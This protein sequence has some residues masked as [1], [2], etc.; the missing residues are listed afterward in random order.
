M[1]ETAPVGIDS[2]I[3]IAEREA[4]LKFSKEDLTF[5]NNNPPEQVVFATGSI[6]KAIMLI[7]EIDNF[8]FKVIEDGK[9]KQIS[10]PL[11]LLKYFNENV[12]NGN[13]S[14]K[15]KTFLGY[16]FGVELYIHPGEGESS[17]NE[18]PLEEAKNKASYLYEEEANGYKGRDILIFSSDTVDKPDAAK[19]PLGK[20]ENE[21]EES[22]FPFP[23]KVDYVGD[24]AGFE[25]AKVEYLIAWKERFYVASKEIIHTNAI[26]VLD[27]LTGEFIELGDLATL[28]LNVPIDHDRLREAIVYHDMA[29]GG[30]LQQ[31]I[32][33][34]NI[35]AILN[36]F[37]EISLRL[38]KEQS[39][40]IIKMA[41]MCQIMGSPHAI[42][43]LV[44]MANEKRGNLYGN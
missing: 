24:D 28:E 22:G 23:Q 26:A 15:V 39:E 31:L 33:W 1:F 43:E 17:S 9:L 34:G 32:E 14:V 27:A 6:R 41:L 7:S 21:N 10:D 18:F 25:A 2:F 37:D 44:R 4:E 5:W 8:S 13:G 36:Y 29:G 30:I 3:E 35:D 38:I 12:Y 40:E 20:P 16:L 19:L 42:I 11:D